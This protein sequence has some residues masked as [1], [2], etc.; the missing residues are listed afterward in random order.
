LGAVARRRWSGFDGQSN[1]VVRFWLGSCA[2][3]FALVLSGGAAVSQSTISRPNDSQST[4]SQS[5]PSQSNPP[6][7]GRFQARVIEVARSLQDHP[8][9]KNLTQKQRE[10]VVEFVVGNMLFVALHELAHTAVSDMRIPVLGREE[11]A[12]DA[13]AILR[14][15]KIG[16]AFSHRVL[17]E[18]TKGWFLSARRDRIDGEPLAFYDEHSLDQQRA[19]QI[20]CLMVGHNPNAM[21]DLANEMKL[22]DDRRD[23]CKKDFTRASWSW[24]EVL[25]RHQREDDQPKTKIEVIYGDGTGDLDAFAKG[26]R[27]VRLLETVAERS[28]DEFAWPTPF[29]LEMKSC[30]FINAR[31]LDETRTLTLC[32]E[33]AADFADLY[34]AFNKGEEAKQERKA[35]VSA[36]STTQSVR[37]SFRTRTSSGAHNRKFIAAAAGARSSAKGAKSFRGRPE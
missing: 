24:D 21:V 18:A 10:D 16:S 7:V 11:D 29:T 12:A 8:R 9:L 14:L 26:F 4:P 34:Q 3:F 28:A 25:R 30:G 19:Y 6:N 23:S 17:G 33:L 15:L 27:T 32:Y 31:W 5:T 13:F 2:V 35:R 22:P 1:N 20:V 36:R 37:P